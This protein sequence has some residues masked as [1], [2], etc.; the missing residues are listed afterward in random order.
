MKSQL[1]LV[2]ITWG[3]QTRL[4]TLKKS[5]QTENS[6]QCPQNHESTCQSIDNTMGATMMCLLHM[7]SAAHQWWLADWWACLH[8][9]LLAIRCLHCCQHVIQAD[10]PALCW[11]CQDP[12]TQSRILTRFAEHCPL[13]SFVCTNRVNKSASEHCLFVGC[14]FQFE[15]PFISE[16]NASA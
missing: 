14:Q 3:K 12:P 16:A 10:I 2:V 6:V 11:V 8:P 15:L 5:Q 9:G 4:A 7:P 13:P 1:P